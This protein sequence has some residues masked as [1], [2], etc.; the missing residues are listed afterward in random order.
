MTTIKVDESKLQQRL[1]AE[2]AGA[3]I[4]IPVTLD[5]E[6][7]I[8]ELSGHIMNNMA[9][10]QAILELRSD[11]AV[12]T[13][14]AAQINLEELAKQFGENVDLKDIVVRVKIAVPLPEIIRAVEEALSREGLTGIVPPLHFEIS[15]SYKGQTVDLSKFNVYI[16]RR[17]AIPDGLDPN[18][19]TTGVVVEPDGSL[20]HVPTRLIEIEGSL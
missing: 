18:R 4:T 16:E 6:V 5:N 8:G 7:I 19:I 9:N 3:V 17:F 2:G 12:Y 20:R 10:L 14:P 11:R 15:V 13:I 1:E